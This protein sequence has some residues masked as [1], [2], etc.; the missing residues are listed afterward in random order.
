M[1]N[2]KQTSYE[3]NKLWRNYN[4]S[5]SPAIR[6]IFVWSHT[7]VSSYD[8]CM[9]TNSLEVLFYQQ[10]GMSYFSSPQVCFA[11]TAVFSRKG[12][13]P[14][15]SVCLVAQGNHAEFDATQSR[16]CGTKQGW[17]YRSGGVIDGRSKNTRQFGR[18]VPLIFHQPVN[19]VLCP[20]FWRRHLE[21]VCDA[22]QGLLGLSIRNNL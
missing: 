2:I 11:K 5:N 1:Y 3:R 15:E 18:G 6:N 4:I 20:V 14:V 17:W 8:T 16:R 9:Y 10:I 19:V 22:Q 12:C 13:T 7:P 21:Y